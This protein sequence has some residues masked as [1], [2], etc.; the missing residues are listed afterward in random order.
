MC[1]FN[2]KNIY[3]EDIQMG[4]HKSLKTPGGGIQ[5]KRSILKRWERI[6]VL[7]SQGIYKEG[8]SVFNLPKTKP[9]K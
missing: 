1:F 2:G 6:D 4:L 5:V 3:L 7:K 8:D 9:P